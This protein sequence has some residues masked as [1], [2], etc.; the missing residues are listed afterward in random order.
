MKRNMVFVG[1][2]AFLSAFAPAGCTGVP[3]DGAYTFRFR[4]ENLSTAAI[5]EVRFLNGSNRS[6]LTLRT[7]SQKFE[8][9]DLS[10]EYTVFGFTD[11]YRVDERY[12][13][14]LITYED[15]DTA[16]NHGHYGPDESKILVTSRDELRYDD[17]WWYEK[18]IELRSGE[19]YW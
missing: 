13:G 12:C 11:A 16:F 4:V 19:D 18:I 17:R 9:N 3:M 2:L 5:T 7:L 6:A 14:V 1:M 15:G 8:K 10:D